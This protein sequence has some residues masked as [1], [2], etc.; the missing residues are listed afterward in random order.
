VESL[1]SARV[2]GVGFLLPGVCSPY[3]PVLLFVNGKRRTRANQGEATSHQTMF[4]CSVARLQHQ[5]SN[6]L[7][8]LI[9]KFINQHKFYLSAA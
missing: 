6:K 3:F 9:L 8:L 5:A 1:L 2:I 7:S 4:G